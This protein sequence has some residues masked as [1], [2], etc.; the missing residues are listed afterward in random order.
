MAAASAVADRLFGAVVTSLR[1][2]ADRGGRHQVVLPASGSC[3]F[4]IPNPNTADPPQLKRAL[5]ERL[6]LPGFD[7]AERTTRGKVEHMPRAGALSWGPIRRNDARHSIL[8]HLKLPDAQ[9]LEH[10]HEPR[11]GGQKYATTILGEA[12]SANGHAVRGQHQPP[13]PASSFLP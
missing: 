1:V 9:G 13:S 8:G 4:K 11:I 2:A 6:R 3:K 12:H 7:R 10:P 5:E